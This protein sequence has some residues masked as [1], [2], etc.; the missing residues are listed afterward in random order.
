MNK[1][2]NALSGMSVVVAVITAGCMTFPRP[3]MISL[4]QAEMDSII[5]HAPAMTKDQAAELVGRV[6]RGATRE[7]ATSTSSYEVRQDLWM[8]I[9]ASRLTRTEGLKVVS[10]A[11]E[12]NTYAFLWEDVSEIQVVRC[13]L[14]G[15]T[16]WY[17]V[18]VRYK[19]QGYTKR[20]LSRS[21]MTP[22]QFSEICKM[23]AN[24]GTTPAEGLIQGESTSVFSG[25]TKKTDLDRRFTL[26]AF[27]I[28]SERPVFYGDTV[29][30]LPEK[31][32]AGFLAALKILARDGTPLRSP[33][34]L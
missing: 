5:S 3:V 23:L 22:E 34:A 18:G 32:L 24:G 15:R 10:E 8:W 7:S 4:S 20:L 25:Y 31:E 27:S 29:T 14:P 30:H 11:I 21:V 12:I 33:S 26:A 19:K 1:R 9:N 17:S 6:C 2:R 28:G 13:Q 16:D